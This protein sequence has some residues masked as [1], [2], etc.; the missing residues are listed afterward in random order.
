MVIEGLHAHLHTST[1]EHP[2]PKRH[3]RFAIITMLLMR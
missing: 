1:V 3:Q 2:S